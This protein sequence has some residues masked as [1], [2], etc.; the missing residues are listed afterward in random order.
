MDNPLH[1]FSPQESTQAE[2]C[3]VPVALPAGGVDDQLE[4]SNITQLLWAGQLLMVH[5]SA[6]WVSFGTI[7]LLILILDCGSSCV[8][9]GSTKHSI[10]A[11]KSLYTDRIS[12][13]IIWV[14]LVLLWLIPLMN[15]ISL[16]NGTFNFLA[17]ATVIRFDCEPG[18]RSARQ[19]SRFPS[20]SL[21][22]VLLASECTTYSPCGCWDRWIYR[23]QFALHYLNSD[24][25]FSHDEAK[26]CG[27]RGKF[28][29]SVADTLLQ[30][31]L[32]WV[33]LHRVPSGQLP[34]FC[35]Q[36]KVSWTL[37]TNLLH[38]LHWR[39]CNCILKLQDPTI[40]FLFRSCIRSFVWVFIVLWKGFS[41][42]ILV[43]I[44]TEQI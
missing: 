12:V 27:A 30:N 14:A 8:I 3:A 32:G 17:K 20:L 5:G 15:L 43:F 35:R 37:H 40:L 23:R 39:I 34:I 26:F 36:W 16:V 18:S 6:N 31:V 33:S 22:Y 13:L 4:F 11:V 25:A 42:W 41:C 38:D 28:Y 9:V 7:I 2:C 44:L 19:R 10:A 1:S 24:W 21:I 29:T